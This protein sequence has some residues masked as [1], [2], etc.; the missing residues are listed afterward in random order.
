MNP[1]RSISRIASF[2]ASVGAA[3]TLMLLATGSIHIAHGAPAPASHAWSANQTASGGSSSNR[4]K[5]QKSCD[6]QTS[7]RGTGSNINSKA[8]SAARQLWCTATT[9]GAHA[10][11]LT[12]DGVVSNREL[13][14]F[15][16][17]D[18]SPTLRVAYAWREYKTVKN[19]K[20]VTHYVPLGYFLV[21]KNGTV[22]WVERF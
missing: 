16:Y 13:R 19:R 15:E 17:A 5:T 10:A 2:T 22:V 3:V 8:N 1:R 4:P 6:D 21:E 9:G 20:S 7:V 18:S 11:L 12:A 14:L